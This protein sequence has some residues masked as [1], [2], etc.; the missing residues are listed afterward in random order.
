MEDIIRNASYHDA[1]WVLKAVE[2]LTSVEGDLPVP[3][4]EL[5][6]KV[7]LDTLHKKSPR[8]EAVRALGKNG[9][10]AATRALVTVL[11]DQ[12]WGSAA[13]SALKSLGWKPRS[14][15]ERVLWCFAESGLDARDA[16]SLGSAAV[17]MLLSML[18]TDSNR[19]NSYHR[20]FA[21]KA[22]GQ[23]GDMSCV[24]RLIQELGER[25]G[26]VPSR[27]K[28][29]VAALALLGDRRAIP[30]LLEWLDLDITDYRAAALAAIKAIDP[31]F[32]ET[33]RP[34]QACPTCAKRQPRLADATELNIFKC[35]A[36]KQIYCDYC[37]GGGL[38]TLPRCPTSVHHEGIRQIGV[39]H[40]SSG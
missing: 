32:D 1:D 26:Y 9:S 34:F 30:A 5:V 25:K 36:C 21:F 10:P 12:S 3:A 13:C 24:D 31:A 40:H 29:A 39:V 22:L 23:I 20:E 4:L 27:D 14:I 18:D 11:P 7:R 35:S 38:V 6:F 37:S 17:P 28:D 33:R 8:L 15:E 2:V 19:W 16:K